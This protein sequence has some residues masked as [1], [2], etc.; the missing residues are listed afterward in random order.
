LLSAIRTPD[1][2]APLVPV[3]AS[4]AF[5]LTHA[6]LLKLLI[7]Q[8]IFYIATAVATYWLAR[9]VLPR[10]WALLA[11]LAVACS[12]G[13]LDES[14]TFLFAEAATAMF[15]AAVAA[16]VAARN[17][18][19]ARFL[20]L[21]GVLGGLTV[22]ARTMM[23]AF[24]GVI[25]VIGLLMVVAEPTN[26][27]QR[28]GRFLL[29]PLVGSSIAA[30][31]Y[32]AQWRFVLDYL[33]GFGY[34]HSATAN[35][36]FAMLPLV[37]SLPSR[38]NY[39]VSTDLYLPL[40]AAVLVGICLGGWSAARAWQ[41]PDR[42]GWRVVLKPHGQIAL[43]AA[44][45]LAAL[46]S[47]ANPGIGFELPLVPPLVVLAVVG[48]RSVTIPGMTR[49]LRTG[50]LALVA[51]T[52]ATTVVLKTL[53][54]I[55]LLTVAVGPGTYSAVVISSSSVT[56]IYG[57]SAG[58]GLPTS[59]VAKGPWL[60]NSW[61]ADAFMYHY[62]AEHG[63]LPV[64]F[65]ATEGPLFNTNTLQLEEQARRGRLLPMG[66]F[67]DPHQVGMSFVQQLYAPSY[68]IPNFLVAVSGTEATRFTLVPDVRAAQTAR[69]AKF[70]AVW[71]LRLPDESW[72]TIYWRA[73]GPRIATASA[74]T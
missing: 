44:G 67:R 64:V 62:A 4:L 17:G 26:R 16:Q 70:R 24:I 23:V 31:W 9:L 7:S 25:W 63:R 37:G 54:F 12:A 1:S 30:V 55:P 43:L 50:L 3:V 6:N 8:Q 45:C 57:L 11:A 49:I 46:C 38:L 35:Q 40:A 41:G 66:V 68:G 47:T 33:I 28:L 73:V 42:L 48:W 22:L 56:S 51:V 36:H 71:R 61:R 72:A 13:M 14:R 5:P 59:E 60:P 32:S 20:V 15:A 27:R 58:V 65:F 19:D 2:Q 74:G 52:S 69:E 21:A 39:L 18:R 34:S 29:V 10:W 53:P